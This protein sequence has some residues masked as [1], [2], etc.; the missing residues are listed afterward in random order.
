MDFVI[1]YNEIGLKG[2]NRK[3][4]EDKL[5]ENIKKSL[6]DYRPGIKKL[7][8]R[9]LLQTEDLPEIIEKLKK[10]FGIANFAQ[11]NVLELNNKLG[12]LKILSEFVIQEL[13]KRKFKTFKIETIRSDKNF[14]LTSQEL[15][16]KLGKR[17]L[18]EIKKEVN[19]NSP[20]IICYIE[21]LSGRA[22]VYFD[23]IS[24]AGGLPTTSAG[25]LV[26]LISGGIDSPVASWFMEKRGA[27]LIFV[28]FHSYPFTSAASQ[29]IVRELVGLLGEWQ[30]GAKL[31]FVPFAD[32]QKKIVESVMSDLRLIFYRRWMARVAEI[33][34]EKEKARG[35]VTGEALGQVASQTLENLEVISNAVSLPWYRPLIG[36][37]KEEIIRKA[38]EIGTYDISIQPF[39]DCCSFLV[40]AHPKTKA[41]IGE[42][43]KIEKKIEKDLREAA[44]NAVKDVKLEELG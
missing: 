40:P 32:I 43:L 7:P 20:D 11:I 1:H 36:F 4:F 10:I 5:I 31:Y 38:R 15:N 18:A 16:E 6:R 13:K 42:V 9:F 34:A 17:I 21:I 33:I 24:G 30:L 19:L 2:K 12:D 25:K 3:F 28:H 23:K 22:L 8:G 29:N 27:K 44:L 39:D 35:L 26:S 41:R 14:F 37:D